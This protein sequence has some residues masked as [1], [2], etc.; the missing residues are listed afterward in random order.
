MEPGASFEWTRLA[1]F[2]LKVRV[3]AAAYQGELSKLREELQM[4]L[5]EWGYAF[6]DKEEH[7]KR[8]LMAFRRRYRYLPGPESGWRQMFS[9]LA[10]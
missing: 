7:L 8:R 10:S 9:I 1:D 2:C 4:K 6:G 3:G 5:E